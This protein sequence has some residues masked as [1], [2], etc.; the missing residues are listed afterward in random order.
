MRQPTR[1][2]RLL[3]L[4]AELQGDDSDR[5]RLL[6]RLVYA[7]AGA[8][9]I[10]GGLI[11]VLAL[12]GVLPRQLWLSVLPPIGAVKKITNAISRS[13]PA[14]TFIGTSVLVASSAAVRMYNIIE[15]ISNRITS[16][17]RPNMPAA[18]IG[19]A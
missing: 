12:S 19:N 4:A 6:M 15:K 13:V 14:V 18:T 5:A 11:L 1:K 17:L 9:V 10:G 7:F 16:R 3:G 8:V 2:S